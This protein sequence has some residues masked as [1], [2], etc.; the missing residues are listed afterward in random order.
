MSECSNKGGGNSFG[1]ETALVPKIMHDQLSSLLE[2]A[3]AYVSL[4]RIERDPGTSNI[5]VF[6]IRDV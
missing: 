2:Q 5:T 4:H 6:S 1:I 3:R